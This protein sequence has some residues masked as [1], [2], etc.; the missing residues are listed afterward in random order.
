MYIYIYIYTYPKP[1]LLQEFMER[2]MNEQVD[3]QGLRELEVQGYSSSVRLGT[4][5]LACA[6]QC[7]DTMLAL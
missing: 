5:P 4:C 6:L 3:L 2:E 1:S 7:D